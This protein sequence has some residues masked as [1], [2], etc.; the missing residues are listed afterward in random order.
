MPKNITP[1]LIPTLLAVAFSGTAS[2]SGFAVTAPI[3]GWTAG[4]NCPS[5]SG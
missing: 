4:P 2:A 5:L 1:R 3:S